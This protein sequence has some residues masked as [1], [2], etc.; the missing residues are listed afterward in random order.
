MS[1]RRKTPPNTALPTSGDGTSSVTPCPTSAAPFFTLAIEGPNTVVALD[2]SENEI[3]SLHFDD[4]NDLTSSNFWEY[5]TAA[6]SAVAGS[7]A[8]RGGITQ[9]VYR[10][11]RHAEDD[12]I[13]LLDSN[14]DEIYIE[15]DIDELFAAV[16]SENESSELAEAH[17][18][19]NLDADLALALK[20]QEEE[21]EEQRKRIGTSGDEGGA[22]GRTHHQRYVSVAAQPPTTAAAAAAVSSSSYSNIMA[23]APGV[24]TALSMHISR[25]GTTSHTISDTE[26]PLLP[27]KLPL[28]APQHSANDNL[29][30]SSSSSSTTF[31]QQ[32]Q[33]VPLKTRMAA[34]RS[35]GIR[36]VN[37][38]QGSRFTGTYRN[39]DELVAAAAV[40]DDSTGRN[41]GQGDQRF[42]DQLSTTQFLDSYDEEAIE[43]RATALRYLEKQQ[44]ENSNNN[45]NNDNSIPTVVSA[46]RQALKKMMDSSTIT[47]SSNKEERDSDDHCT[48]GRYSRRK[49]RT[50]VMSMIAAGWEFM[51]DRRGSG[52]YIY[53]RFIPPTGHKQI[54]VLPCTP[55]S[56]R[57]IEAVHSRLQRMDREAA[58]VRAAALGM[59]GGV[60]SE[61]LE[62]Y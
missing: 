21:E 55:S 17:A 50:L 18:L 59:E 19:E 47:R 24:S 5:A 31:L 16:L 37:N 62:I 44:R 54:L 25:N 4:F 45:N 28:S 34:E 39:H 51:S 30:L 9:N 38:S 23:T 22:W 2:S 27:P 53:Q 43:A 48:R 12:V 11:T 60:G 49:I 56:Q 29:L 6:V 3:V 61:K 58:A 10:G 32:R 41:H 57:S 33:R 40:D 35:T 20:L 15:D 14:D 8:E 1:R 13:S 36:K 52:H 46:S 7:G 26:F 42:S